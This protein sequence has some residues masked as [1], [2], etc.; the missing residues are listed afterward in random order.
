[1]FDIWSEDADKIFII[2][3]VITFYIENIKIVYERFMKK[4]LAYSFFLM[5]NTKCGKNDTLGNVSSDQKL[6]ISRIYVRDI[7][8]KR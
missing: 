8:K 6:L 1:M 5:Y 4:T 7:Y 2:V 3:F